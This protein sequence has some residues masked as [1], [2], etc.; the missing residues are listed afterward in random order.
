MDIQI[1]GN[2]FVQVAPS[3]KKLCIIDQ[4]PNLL[5]FR[6]ITKT[7]DVPYCDCFGV[8]EEF[9][10]IMPAG[11][12]SSSVLRITVGINWYKS[13]M[14]KSVITSNSIKESKVVWGEYVDY[15]K[16]NGNVFKEKKKES[17][18]SHGIEKLQAKPQEDKA[19]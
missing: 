17:K 16:K 8:D 18:L 4:N 10:C 14:M 11:C 7:K 5:R 9:L 6:V 19:K 15:I 12:Q 3:F 2:P 1:K 13:T